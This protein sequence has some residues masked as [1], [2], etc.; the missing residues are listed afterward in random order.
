MS[1]V[2]GG[3][4]IGKRHVAVWSAINIITEIA[5][6][7]SAIRFDR[8]SGPISLFLYDARPGQIKFLQVTLCAILIYIVVKDLANY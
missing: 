6:L 4:L 3:K 8:G 7:T 2:E 5:H 1:L